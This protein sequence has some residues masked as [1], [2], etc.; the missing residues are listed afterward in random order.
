MGRELRL[1]IKDQRLVVVFGAMADK[2]LPAMCE[3]LQRMRPVA[4]VFTAAESAGTRA[5][6]PGVLAH[7]YGQGS[8][9]VTPSRDAL[10]RGRALA[11]RDGV[12]LAC[13]SLYL[14]GELRATLVRA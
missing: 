1:L 2:D 3:R 12:V 11:G 13:G 10:E 8:E 9:V 7:L 14:I 5:A 6:D 4:A